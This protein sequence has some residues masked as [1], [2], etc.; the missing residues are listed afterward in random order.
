M[1]SG[2]RRN[3]VWLG[4]AKLRKITVTVPAADLEAAQAYAGKGITVTVREGLRKLASMHA[5]QELQKLRGTFK[6][7]MNL[8]ELREDR[9]F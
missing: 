4:M 6:F 1:D 5:Q 2:F 9:E 3:D 7:S 8:D